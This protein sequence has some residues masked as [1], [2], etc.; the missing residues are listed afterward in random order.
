MHQN[1]Q[2]WK[3]SVRWVAGGRRPHGWLQRPKMCERGLL[4]LNR[5]DRVE[6]AAAVARGGRTTGVAE[7]RDWSRRRGGSGG[8]R[9]R[10][11]R[12]RLESAAGWTHKQAS[13]GQIGDGGGGDGGHLSRRMVR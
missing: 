6:S 1:F 3:I 13:E 11:K 9:K 2:R 10:R 8:N 12:G 7:G 4:R 5:R